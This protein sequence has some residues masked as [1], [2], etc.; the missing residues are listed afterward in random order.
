MRGGYSFVAPA[1]PYQLAWCYHDKV[2]F[3]M[4]K[5]VYGLIFLV[6][7]EKTFQNTGAEKCRLDGSHTLYT[8]G[9]S[10]SLF[11]FGGA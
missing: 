10:D 6:P 11:V 2:G 8:L 7:R 3:L 9:I 4:N 5:L 1:C